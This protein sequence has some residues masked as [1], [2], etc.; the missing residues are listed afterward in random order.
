MGDAV[1]EAN[2]AF[3]QRFFQAM[4]E[5]DIEHIVNAYADD[6]F[7]QTMGNTLI[8]GTYSKEQVR[9]AAGA[10]YDVFPEGLAFTILGIAA[11]GDR[12]AVEATSEGQHISGQT[13]SNHYHFLFELRDGRLLCLKEFMDTE[14]AT[15]ILCGGQRP[16]DITD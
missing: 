13:Y 15:D 11:D 6:G 10:I 1:T 16:G 7:L 8:S 5:G 2:R 9:A 14:R 12:V 3:V 4:N